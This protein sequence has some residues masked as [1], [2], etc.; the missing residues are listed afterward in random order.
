MN[1]WSD[2]L[3]I[4]RFAA[5]EAGQIAM[6]Y[7][8]RSPKVF[9][10]KEGGSPVSDADI[11]VNSYLESFLRPLRPSYGWLSEETDDNF[12]RLAHETLFIIDPI[13]GT[14]A[15]ILGDRA[16]CIS[17]A[18]VHQGRP[19]AGVINASALGQ[20]FYVCLGIE[21]SCDGKNISVSSSSIGDNLVVMAEEGDLVSC[22]NCE[23][24]QCIPSLALRLSMVADGRIDAALVRRNAS[25]WDLA[26]VDLLLE[27]AGGALVNLDGQSLI[28]NRSH[29]KHGILI[30]SAKRH[31]PTFLDQLS[32]L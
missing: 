22:I 9:R 8:C 26:A 6:K 32:T 20:E 2:D 18:V 14:R 21:S 10:E 17:I 25:D 24:I 29:V 28:Y 5:R 19:V 15:F 13:D 11:A 30:A 23:L 12:E 16:W 3:N 27:R 4:I 31:L 1:D 7:F